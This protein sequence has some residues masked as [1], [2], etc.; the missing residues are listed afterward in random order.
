MRRR[1]AILGCV[2]AVLVLGVAVGLT[3]A[4][5]PTSPG[6]RVSVQ[7]PVGTAFT[8]QGQ[9]RKDGSPYS[10]TCDFR[11]G[12]Y[13]AATGGAQVGTTQARS[14]VAVSSGLFLIPDL[15]FGAGAFQGDAR[16]LEVAVR[17]TGDADY[18]TLSPRQALTPVPYALYTV[19]A[20]WSGLQGVPAGFA[21]GVDNDS[22][23]DITAVTAGSGLSGG[24]T[25]GNVTLTL[26][27]G[28]TDARYWRLLG[29]SGTISGTH[30]LGT[31]DN[32]P[33]DFRV[34]NAR[35][36]RLEPNPTS[37][38]VLGGQGVNSVSAGVYGATI[39][40]GGS[41]SGCGFMS[42]GACPNRV[43]DN[44]GTV[45]GGRDNQAGDNAGTTSDKSYATVGG[46]WGNRASGSAATVGGGL[47][48]TAS[49]GNAA[50]AGGDGNVAAGDHSTICGGHDNA[51][52][53]DE[54]AV[55]GGENNTASGIASTVAGGQGN[56]AS[57]PV[58]AVGGGWENTASD[59][60]A[61]VAGGHSNTASA[62]YATVGG[63]AEN[64]ASGYSSAVG[65]GHTNQAAGF[66]ATVGGGTDNRATANGATIPGGSG[67]LADHVGQW[68]YASGTFAAVGDAQAGLFVL[69]N[70]SVGNAWTDLYLDGSSVWITV[71]SGRTISFQIV[72]AGR[73]NGGESAGYRIQGVVENVAGTTALV[74]TPV[75][76]ILGEDDAAW[77]AR[78]TADTREDALRVQV[79]GN[80]ETIRWVATVQ[81]AEVAW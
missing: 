37:P 43:T 31:T 8:Y 53:E 22:G 24:G 44:Y 13:D 72:V 71:A 48:N 10:G 14:A 33:L 5:G 7:A 41:A 57:G 75:V 60:E 28:F 1:W 47:G 68:A 63:G 26:D 3:Q 54:A 12:L 25:S 64:T 58:S 15:D 45:G 2:V 4:Q 34:Q 65:G 78:V 36:L 32:Q 62:R 59:D 16:W 49:G 46:G 81:T 18:T 11:F 39:G 38:N 9:L 55:G 19:A 79:R 40:G 42:T 74:G 61:T 20:P 69:R 29:N 21:D 73:S 23:G 17:C 50:V 51:A 6:G 67:A 52:S 27:T 77:D 35:A 76:T 70:T 56:T 30:F 80:G 66:Y